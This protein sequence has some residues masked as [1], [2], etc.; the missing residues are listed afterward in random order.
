MRQF[1]NKVHRSGYSLKV[2]EFV[3]AWMHVYGR[4]K[5]NWEPELAQIYN[6]FLQVAA[7]AGANRSCAFFGSVLCS[8]FDLKD[9]LTMRLAQ[10][11]TFFPARHFLICVVPQR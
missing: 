3:R 5:N 2:W 10:R 7:Y 1:E 4:G 11:R 8:R 9:T 6:F